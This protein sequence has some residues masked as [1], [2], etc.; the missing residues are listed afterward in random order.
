MLMIDDHINSS[1]CFSDSITQGAR[2]RINK[3]RAIR[4]F[5]NQAIYDSI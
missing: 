2:I 4:D 1:F 5:N 3:K